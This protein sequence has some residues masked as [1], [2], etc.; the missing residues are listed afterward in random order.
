MRETLDDSKNSARNGSKASV[1]K[2][3]GS[4]PSADEIRKR[5]YEIFQARQGGTEIG[6][7]QK[8]EAAA[9]ADASRAD[10]SKAD[11]SLE[12]QS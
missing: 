1:A 10:A 7:W 4:K 9:S 6:D 11:A 2:P 3:N 8:A 12:A 5:A